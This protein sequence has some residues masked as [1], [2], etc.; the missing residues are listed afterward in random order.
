MNEKTRNILIT[1]FSVCF[2]F[3]F[4]LYLSVL[5]VFPK[6]FNSD[7]FTGQLSEEFRK[8][9]GLVLNIEKLSVKPEFSPFINLHAHHIIIK[10]RSDIIKIRD[11]DLKLK[12]LPLITKTVAIEKIN[13]DYPIIYVNMDKDGTADI[14]KYLFKKYNPSK[15]AG[16]FKFSDTIPKTEIKNYKIKIFDKRYKYPFVFEGNKL[17]TEKTAFRSNLN[18]LTDGSL[19]Y[20]KEPLVKYNIDSEIP[21]KINENRERLFNTNPFEYLKKYNIRANLNSKLKISDNGK[22]FKI[23]GHT[24]IK[25]LKFV[26]D[27]KVMSDNYINLSFNEGKTGIEASIN[28]NRQNLIRISGEV[29][30]GRIKLFVKSKESDI[31]TLKETAEAILNSFNIKNDLNLFNIS[32]KTDLDFSVESN[33]KT[34]K[35]SGAAKIINASI[36]HKQFSYTITDINSVIN[37]DQNQI[38]LEPS[39]IYIN[40]TPVTVQGTV[41]NDTKLNIEAEGKNLD[42]EKLT[43]LFLPS[44]VLKNGQ[45]RGTADFKAQI[46]GTLKKP[47]LHITSD[48]SNFVQIKDNKT[49]IRF[50][51]GKVTYKGTKENPDCGIDITN[52]DIL[53]DIF[54]SGLTAEKIQLS[55]DLNSVTIPEIKLMDKEKPLIISGRID[56]LKKQPKYK[57]DINGKIKSESLYKILK[58]KNIVKNLNAAA[59]GY[60]TVNGQVNGKNSEGTF[61][62]NI[63]ADKDNYISFIVINE[64]LNRPSVMNIDLSY[65]TNSIAINNIS[66]QNKTNSETVTEIKGRINDFAKPKAEH[67]NVNIPKAMSVSLSQLKNSSVT[68]KSNIELNGDIEKPDIKGTLEI[69]DIYIPDYKLSSSVNEIT[70]ADDL[71]KINIPKLI[72]GSTKLSAKAETASDFKNNLKYLEIDADYID[73]DELNEIFEPLSNNSVYPGIALPFSTD[74]GTAKVRTFKTAGL[75]AENINCDIKTENNIVKINNIKGTAYKGLLSG[76]AEYNTLMTKTYCDLTG[77]NADIAPLMTAITGVENFA[78]GKINFRMK[79]NTIGIKLN[80]QQRTAKGYVQ[81]TAQNGIMGPL[82]RFEHFL[83]AQNLISQSI[84]KTT[85]AAVSKVLKPQNT[86]I[87]T[88]ANGILEIES[89]TAD[90]KDLSLEGPN[91]SLFI[92][93]KMNIPNNRVDLEIYGRVSEEIEKFLGNL[94][95]PMPRT[96]LSTSS[97]TSLGNIFYDEYN[98]KVTRDIIGKIPPL[99]PDTGLSARPFAVKIQGPSESIKSVKSFKWIT[100]IENRTSQPE[101]NSEPEQIRKNINSENNINIKQETENKLPDFMEKLPDYSD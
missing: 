11:M 38:K 89:G 99:N 30:D 28:S 8:N 75:T 52:A 101:R 97:E 1:I 87:Y 10:D 63:L 44:D 77:Q 18:L 14:D 15:K 3:V 6:Y 27:G 19:T 82:C 65:N 23:N 49:V 37:F 81:F 29:S 60:L 67:L 2:G 93:G 26:V 59:K 100:G 43:K 80:Q 90:F 83:Y 92:K 64:L 78:T 88:I 20:N 35:S 12:V 66:L 84:M 51:K 58:E 21:L 48:L 54:N 79:L 76:K 85:V 25:N 16:I 46:S 71:I 50:N 9:T 62:G 96:I 68:L 17:I 47:N 55:T 86:G 34:L 95:N 70:F 4:V 41:S 32:G 72:I 22:I 39:K 94:K 53:P 45:Y 5:L 61:K 24:N 13:A 7:Y 40:S 36:K 74:K 56:E 69:K 73:L 31:K 91:M 33:Y 57:F 42:I 98:T